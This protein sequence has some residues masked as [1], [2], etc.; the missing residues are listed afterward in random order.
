MLHLKKKN[1]DK[2]NNNN[3]TVSIRKVL[4]ISITKSL[5]GK[6]VFSLLLK[7]DTVVVDLS[8]CGGEFQRGGP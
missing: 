3:N 1:I 5:R 6:N 8:S 7:E 4:L 2:S